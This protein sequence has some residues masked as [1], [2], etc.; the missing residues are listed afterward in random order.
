MSGAWFV[1][2]WG[3]G[4]REVLGI[5][6]WA[7]T[8]QAF[9]ALR[10]YV[11]SSHTLFAFDLPGC[12]RSHAA[13]ELTLET[14]LRPLLDWLAARPRPVTLVGNCSGAVFAV[15]AASRLPARVSRLVLIDPFA[16]LPWYFRLFLLGSPGRLAYLTTFANPLGRGLTNGA[17]RR[18]RAAGTDLT[19]GFRGVDHAAMLAYLRLLGEIGSP[20][21]L[22]APVVGKLDATPVLLVHGA[23]TFRAV[24]SSVPLWREALPHLRL[25]VLAGAGHFPLTEATNELARLIFDGSAGERRA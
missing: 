25:R 19:A 16:Y 21:Q 14:V 20:A 22:L 17:L 4:P 15:A 12:G 13:A 3:G 1:E 2:R 6:G 24:K 18:R 23:R 11:D 10:P 5:H 9:A 7:G 8:H